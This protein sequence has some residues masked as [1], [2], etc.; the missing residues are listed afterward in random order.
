MSEKF[1]VMSEKPDVL[2][3]YNRENRVFITLHPKHLQP[4]MQ[5]SRMLAYTA[6]DK[7]LVKN[8]QWGE[9]LI[10]VMKYFSM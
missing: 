5:H 9:K 3:S 7:V 1:F 8:S 6:P 2:C 4:R 10:F